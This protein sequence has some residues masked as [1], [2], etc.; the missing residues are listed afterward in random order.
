[1]ELSIRMKCSV[2]MLSS[3]VTASHM[4]LLSIFNVASTTKEQNVRFYLFIITFLNIYFEGE[5]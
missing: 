5:R 1:M 4:G 3:R 2:F